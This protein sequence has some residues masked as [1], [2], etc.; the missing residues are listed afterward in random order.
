MRLSDSSVLRFQRGGFAPRLHLLQSMAFGSLHVGRGSAWAESGRSANASD[1]KAWAGRRSLSLPFAAL[2][3]PWGALPADL[4][5]LHK[6][7]KCCPRLRPAAF[8]GKSQLPSAHLQ[9]PCIAVA[10]RPHGLPGTLTANL[11][12]PAARDGS[13]S[14]P[15]QGRSSVP[16][17]CSPV[18][19]E[20]CGSLCFLSPTQNHEAL[21]SLP[22]PALRCHL[23]LIGHLMGGFVL[24]FSVSFLTCSACSG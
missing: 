7:G 22:P 14:L 23:G 20:G 9:P 4:G 3:F 16:S 21:P 18:G 17:E 1:R 13:A 19:R 12:C 24:G 6:E 15:A 8:F 5:G 10:A 11:P 2:V